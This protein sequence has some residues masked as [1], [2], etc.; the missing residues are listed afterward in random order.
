MN[1]PFALMLLPPIALA[2]CTV[3][4]TAAPVRTGG[5]VPVP[6]PY[7]SVGLERVL[8]QD[9]AGLTKLFGTADADVREGTARKLQ[10]QGRFCVLDAYLY[11]KDGAEPRVTYIDAR[12]P[13][14]SAIDRASCVAALTRRDGGR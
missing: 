3:P 8:G 2:G 14:G 6:V 4:Q 13:D 1:R 11:P 9:A 10:Y 5:M 7:T 12:E